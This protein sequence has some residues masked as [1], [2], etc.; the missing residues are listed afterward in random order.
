MAKFVQIDNVFINVDLVAWVRS[1]PFDCN[2]TEVGFSG[3][4]PDSTDFF[5]AEV[6]HNGAETLNFDWPLAH[7]VTIITGVNYD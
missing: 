5:S 3:A 4:R 1:S 7:V 2:V 6:A